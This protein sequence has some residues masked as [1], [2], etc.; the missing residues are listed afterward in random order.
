MG[1]WKFLL[2]AYPDR[3]L[4]QHDH[5]MSSIV[6]DRGA[7]SAAVLVMEQGVL[8]R[9]EY[10]I[11]PDPQTAQGVQYF[12]EEGNRQVNQLLRN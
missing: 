3:R 12:A 5:Q 8:L 6:P 11:I 7:G 1:G 9:T 4:D 10:G 2:P